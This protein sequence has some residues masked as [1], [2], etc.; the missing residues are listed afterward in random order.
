MDY[1]QIDESINLMDI[2]AEQF[3]MVDVDIWD[4]FLLQ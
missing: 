2:W 3:W 1:S 4:P